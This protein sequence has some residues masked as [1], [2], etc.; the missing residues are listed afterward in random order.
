MLGGACVG[1]IL[2]PIFYRSMGLTFPWIALPFAVISIILLH[3][4][5][6]KPVAGLFGDDLLKSPRFFMAVALLVVGGLLTYPYQKALFECLSKAP[7]EAW[8]QCQK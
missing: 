3:P 1:L 8:P 2:G 5:M 6:D 7:R 4:L